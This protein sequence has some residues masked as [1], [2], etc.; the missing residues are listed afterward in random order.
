LRSGE[1]QAVAV[2]CAQRRF[3]ETLLEDRPAQARAPAVGGIGIARSAEVGVVFVLLE[4]DLT[5]TAADVTRTHGLLARC[6]GAAVGGSE[7]VERFADH[8]NH[9]R[10][11]RKT[12]GG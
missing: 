6:E 3:P 1:Q 5:G 2:L 4:I 9:S 10:R 7:F 12:F 11:T 8:R